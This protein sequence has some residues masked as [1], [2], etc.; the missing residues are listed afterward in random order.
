MYIYTR[1]IRWQA[2][3]HRDAMVGH[4]IGVASFGG[5]HANCVAPKRPTIT[6]LAMDHHH[7]DVAMDIRRVFAASLS[8]PHAH[9]QLLVSQ[10]TTLGWIFSVIYGLT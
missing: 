1:L 5:L 7:R 9:I 4:P 10:N 3:V 6:P 2:V 8:L